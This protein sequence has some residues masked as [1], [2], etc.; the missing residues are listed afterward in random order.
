MITVLWRGSCSRMTVVLSCSRI[1]IG[2]SADRDAG[3]DRA[4]ADADTNLISECR[5]TQGES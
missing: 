4:D 5:R 3:S 1:V 2:R